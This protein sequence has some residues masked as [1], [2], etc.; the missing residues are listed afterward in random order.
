MLRVVIQ[1]LIL[2][3]FVL[4]T[5]NLCKQFGPKAGPTFRLIVFLKEFS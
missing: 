5:D 4:S 3:P 1:A 2:Y